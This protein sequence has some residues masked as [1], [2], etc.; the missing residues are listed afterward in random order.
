MANG[1]IPKDMVIDHINGNSK[2]NRI[3]NLRLVTKGE[4][5]LN[6]KNKE[7]SSGL[8]KNVNRIT[9]GF[10]VSFGI[11]AGSYEK[12]SDA[13]EASLFASL[14]WFGEFS[15][16]HGGVASEYEG[17]PLAIKVKKFLSGEIDEIIHK[18][19]APPIAE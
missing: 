7:R 2:D 4:N 14:R 9:G 15:R 8:P 1:D 19:K 6:R 16:E 5:S 17:E 10:S 13:S 18:K 3:A 12:L 11:S